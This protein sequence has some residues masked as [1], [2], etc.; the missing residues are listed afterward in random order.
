M[1]GVKFNTLVP[2][3]ETKS[4]STGKQISVLSPYQLDTFPMGM[5]TNR[6]EFSKKKYLLKRCCK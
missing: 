4:R 3:V 2:I 5:K 1:T 6:I